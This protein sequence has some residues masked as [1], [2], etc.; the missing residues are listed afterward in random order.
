VRKSVLS[1]LSLLILFCGCVPKTRW[2]LLPDQIILH[3]KMIQQMREETQRIHT[4]TG[5]ARVS[6]RTSAGRDAMEEVILLQIPDAVRLESWNPAGGLQLLMISRGKRGVFVVPGEFKTYEFASEPGPLKRFL[7]LDLSIPDL[8]RILMGRPPLPP[9]EPDHILIELDHE[10]TMLK[11]L[12]DRRVI[13]KVWMDPAGR[14]IRWER[15]NAKGSP[16]ETL[17]FDD[18]RAVEGISIPYHITYSG[19]EG[20]ELTLRY[21][22]LLLNQAI[23]GSLFETT[24]M[25]GDHRP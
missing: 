23:E 15:L 3:Q 20:V 6:I 12:N 7:G 11:I 5:T 10:E 19:S 25:N 17:V 1:F 16:V 2:F 21:R 4:L 24:N 13:Q 8:I 18:F 9:L 22:S 14:I